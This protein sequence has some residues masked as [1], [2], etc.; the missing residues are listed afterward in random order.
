MNKRVS[1]DPHFTHASS[2]DGETHFLC[3]KLI[4]IKLE[5]TLIFT[6]I[7]KGK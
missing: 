7:F 1:V 6:F 5:S 3:E 4:F 2:L